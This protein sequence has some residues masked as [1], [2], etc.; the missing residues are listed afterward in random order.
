MMLDPVIALILHFDFPTPVNTLQILD[1][2]LIVDLYI[3]L[4]E[5]F[6]QDSC[7]RTEVDVRS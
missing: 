7:Q 3:V 4:C 6:K 5:I 2:V 1:A